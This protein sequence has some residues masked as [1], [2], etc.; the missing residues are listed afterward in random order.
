MTHHTSE[1]IKDVFARLDVRDGTVGELQ[2]KQ[3]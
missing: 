2:A 1:D 3:Y